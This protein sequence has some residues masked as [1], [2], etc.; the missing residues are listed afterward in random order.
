MTDH[1]RHTRGTGPEDAEPLLVRQFLDGHAGAPDAAPTWPAPAGPD[2][3]PAA[4]PPPPAPPAGPPPRDPRRRRLI[5]AGAAAAAVLAL[6]AAG[7]A[8]L[9]PGDDERRALPIPA[10]TLPPLPATTDAAPTGTP[11]PTTPASFAVTGTTTAAPSRTTN[12]P[13]TGRAP[14]RP[15]AAAAPTFAPTRVSPTAGAPL[16]APPAAPRT[17]RITGPGGRCLDRNDDR[18]VQVSD[19]TTSAGQVWTF[20]AAG[21]LQ[22]L[23]SCANLGGDGGVNLVSCDGRTTARWRP[24]ADGTLVNLAGEQCLTDPAGGTRSGVAVRVALCSGV[25]AQRWSLP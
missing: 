10:G 21:T 16:A 24:G 6:G 17:G 18:Q 14:A 5:A 4:D 8:A 3:E 19:C 23:G 22:V 2:P 11:A 12:P 15:P 25:A 13:P 7:L 20:T 1:G 9:L